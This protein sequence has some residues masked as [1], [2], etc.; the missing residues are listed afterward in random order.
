[1]V[2]LTEQ[3]LERVLVGSEVFVSVGEPWDFK[4]ADG[5]G[6]VNGRVVKVEYGDPSD[7][8]TQRVRLAVTPFEVEGG[9]TINYLT[10]HRRYADATG[11]I[12]QLASGEDVDVNL[13]YDDQV[14]ARKLPE[15]ISSFLIGGVILS[16]WQQD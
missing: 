8:R 9:Y 13:G 10:A 1:M 12:E 6:M 16:E 2:T 14:D 7:T 3:Q 15:G 4:S 5:E 11:I